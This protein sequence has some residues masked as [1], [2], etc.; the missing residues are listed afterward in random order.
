MRRRWTVDVAPLTM[1]W[2]LLG[3]VGFITTAAL[4]N[5]CDAGGCGMNSD[6]MSTAAWVAVGV[7]IGPFAIAGVV[8]VCVVV[9]AGF[10][11]GRPRRVREPVLE[12]LRA[13]GPQH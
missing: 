5:P 4:T 12:D 8:F 3:L 7:W 1:A 11:H 13:R 9:A 2:A 10:W 6:V